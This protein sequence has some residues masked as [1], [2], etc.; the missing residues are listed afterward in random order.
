MS[1]VKIVNAEGGSDARYDV[2]QMTPEERANFDSEGRP[3]GVGFPDQDVWTPGLPGA[4]GG[5]SQYSMGGYE[6]GGGAALDPYTAQLKAMLDSQSAAGAADTRSAIQQALIGFGLVPQGY[7]DEMGALDDTTRALIQ[8]NTDT[9]ISGYA[10]LLEGKQDAERNLINSLGA[11]GLRR[12]GAKGYMQ[13][14][15]Q[16]NFDRQSQDAISALLANVG[17]LKRSFAD[18]EQQRK[19]QLMQALFSQSQKSPWQVAAP[20]IAAA[21]PPQQ[22]PLQ[23]AINYWQSNPAPT[24]TS[25][26]TGQQW[27]GGINGY[28]STPFRG[29]ALDSL[30]G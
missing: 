3:L 13:R 30:M 5:D 29:K 28:E 18:A 20:A 27:Y 14:R 7:R 22:T 16:L 25:P 1:I 19:M 11:K 10:R 23:G 6:G 4:R 15:G 17:G 12:S 8:K 26:K 2:N 21:A 24:Y 9:G